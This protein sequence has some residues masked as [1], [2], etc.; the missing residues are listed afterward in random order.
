MKN[1]DEPKNCW[2]YWSCI[3]SVKEKCIVYQKNYGKKCWFL[4]GCCPKRGHTFKNCWECPWYIQ[5]SFA[6]AEGRV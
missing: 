5:S 6:E 2:E 4:K 3:K 1:S